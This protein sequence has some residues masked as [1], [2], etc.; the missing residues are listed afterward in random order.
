MERINAK[1]SRILQTNSAEKNSFLNTENIKYA[2]VL[3][4]G[5]TAGSGCA[6]LI[7]QGA[8]RLIN[9]CLFP[10]LQKKHDETIKFISTKKIEELVNKKVKETIGDR[11]RGTIPRYLT[12][13][14]VKPGNQEQMETLLERLTFENWGAYRK[15]N[16]LYRLGI[17]LQDYSGFLMGRIPKKIP[18]ADLT[19]KCFYDPIINHINIFHKFEGSVF[20]EIEHA[21]DNYRGVISRL[22]FKLRMV[23]ELFVLPALITTAMISA[24]VNNKTIDKPPKEKEPTYKNLCRFTKNHIGA[25]VFA[26]FI[27]RLAEEVSA[28]GRAIRFINKSVEVSKDFKQKHAKFLQV[29]FASYLA[30]AAATAIA[31]KTAVMI[32]DET[33]EFL[34]KKLSLKS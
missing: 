11:K 16:P 20:H 5:I 10:Y 34:N 33:T 30:F 29:A 7:D 15:K 21:G 13:S 4:V 14:Y 18:F 9:D 19:E 1:N 31:A 6:Y 12:F 17:R 23:S 2:A 28:S 8:S 32:K 27:P 26:T 22:P 3:P 24:K 25:L